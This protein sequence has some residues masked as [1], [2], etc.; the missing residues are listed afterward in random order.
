MNKKKRSVLYEIYKYDLE[1]NA[2]IIEV[3]LD[4]YV[5]I[6][7]D[8]DFAPFKRKDIAPELKIY[9]EDCA[10]DI[11]LNY[12]IMIRM[13]LPEDLYEEKNEKAVIT[14]INNYFRLMVALEERNIRPIYKKTIR[15]ILLAL[16]F[17][18]TSYLFSSEYISLP[19]KI[20]Q[21]GVLVGGWVFAWEAFTEFF[22]ES[23]EVRKL[24]VIYKRFLEAEV[25]FVYEKPKLR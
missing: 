20:L 3:D 25:K 7:N 12:N 24:I 22:I 10:A 15:Y 9:L 13:H 6:F 1:K 4:T 23:K 2:F 14:G 8:W 11:P 5:E 16:C 21:E 18:T 17:L 19:A